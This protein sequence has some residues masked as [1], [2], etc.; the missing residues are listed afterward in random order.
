[1]NITHDLNINNKSKEINNYIQLLREN[2]RTRIMYKFDM[3][4]SHKILCYGYHLLCDF[5]F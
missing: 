1:M 4:T 2:I 3:V 5:P